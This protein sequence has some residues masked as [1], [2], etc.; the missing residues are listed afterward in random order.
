[1]KEEID[2]NTVDK[3]WLS[4]K[5]MLDQEM[6]VE[7]RRRRFLW[8]WLALLLLPLAAIGGWRLAFG[9]FNENTPLKQDMSAPAMPYASRSNE[10]E[11]PVGGNLQANAAKSMGR[12]TEKA[13]SFTTKKQNPHFGSS[14]MLNEKRINGQTEKMATPG[15]QDLSGITIAA[16]EQHLTQEEANTASNP[17][18]TA[19]LAR[20]Q[21]KVPMELLPLPN[22]F[23]QSQERPVVPTP[24]SIN[25]IPAENIITPAAKNGKWAF[26]ASTII[27]TQ[28]LKAINTVGGG[29]SIH[30]Q[31][32][33]RWG[34]R[35]GVYYAYQSITTSVQPVTTL[36]FSQYN[37]ILNADFEIKDSDGN[38]VYGPSNYIGQADAVVVPLSK[39]SMLELPMLLSYQLPKNWRLFAG[40]AGSYYLGAKARNENYAANSLRLKA[41]TDPAMQNLDNFLTTNINQWGFDVQGGVSYGLGKGWEIGVFAKRPMIPLTGSS[42]FVPTNSFLDNSFANLNNRLP[43]TFLLQANYCF[44]HN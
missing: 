39:L 20:D 7:G 27:G 25:S 30:W 21:E 44:A 38:T 1:M 37:E 2:D 43:M 26:G 40:V 14:R 12:I 35:S 4:M 36:G 32:V 42:D 15:S 22:Q 18:N 3:A 6:P 13:P 34:I 31:P 8:W 19:A 28:R 10:V 29:L 33:R 41:N 23:V 24:V 17:E 11:A 9:T 16:E 5:T